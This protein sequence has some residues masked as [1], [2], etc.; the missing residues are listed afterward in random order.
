MVNFN[1]I[2]YCIGPMSK[3]IVD[4][5]I[6]FCNNNKIKMI[7]IPSRRQIDFDGGY[8]NNWKTKDFCEYVRSETNL[9]YLERDHSGPGQ[10]TYMDD[11]LES[12]SEDCKYFDLKYKSVLDK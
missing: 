1:T 4:S 7:I 9:I 11:G 2:K 8:V 5:I 12:L 10:G 3:N 6:T